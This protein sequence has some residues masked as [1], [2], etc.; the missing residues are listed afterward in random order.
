VLINLLKPPFKF[1][2]NEI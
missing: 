1:W 2:F